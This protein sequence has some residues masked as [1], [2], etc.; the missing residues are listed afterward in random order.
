MRLKTFEFIK[1]VSN[2]VLD[3]INAG[4]RDKTM[5]FIVATGEAGLHHRAVNEANSCL[6]V[7]M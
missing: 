6:L 7:G 2:I 4:Y 3:M 1:A 5:A